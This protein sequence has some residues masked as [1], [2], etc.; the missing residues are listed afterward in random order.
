MLARFVRQ[1][2]VKCNPC[3]LDQ[4]EPLQ[5][6]VEHSKLLDR[7]VSINLDYDSPHSDS[8]RHRDLGHGSVAPLASRLRTSSER[9]DKFRLLLTP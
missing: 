1:L 4:P 2:I 7:Q 3:R 6:I 8:S 9:V 5:R